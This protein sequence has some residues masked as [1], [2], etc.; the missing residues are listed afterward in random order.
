MPLTNAFL[1]FTLLLTVLLGY[2][3]INSYHR[4]ERKAYRKIVSLSR[5]SS[6]VVIQKQ[7]SVSNSIFANADLGCGFMSV[8]KSVDDRGCETISFSLPSVQYYSS[9]VHQQEKT[10]VAD[11][12]FCA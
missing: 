5:Q 11:C 3:L 6:N 2:Q 7:S 10:A 1:W 9:P 12:Q 8:G 4:A